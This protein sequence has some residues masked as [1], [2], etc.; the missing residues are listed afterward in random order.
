MVLGDV[1]KL[2]TTT[3]RKAVSS[4]TLTG[5]FEFEREREQPLNLHALSNSNGPIR[6]EDET[7]I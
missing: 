5:P 7:D 2:E 1:S 6:D 3:A 4:S